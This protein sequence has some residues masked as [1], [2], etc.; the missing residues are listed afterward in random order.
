[1]VLASDLLHIAQTTFTKSFEIIIQLGAICAVVVVYWKKLWNWETIKKLVVAFIPTGVVGLVL[2]KIVKAYL[3]GN[4][5]VVLW[6]LLIGGIVII[7]F[8]RLYKE[9]S[10]AVASISEISYKQAFVIGVFQSVAIVPG[11]SRSLATVIGGLWMGLRRK[12][13]VEFSFLL[14][15]PTMLAA[16]GLD[17]V[18]NHASFSIDQIASLTIGFLVSFVVALFAIRFLL[19]YIQKN[20]FTVFGWYRIAIAILFWLIIVR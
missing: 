8:E 10:G 17:I 3:V 18:K 16:S 1:M 6:A 11:V 5:T 14:A 7:I 4:T 9:Y 19:R 15:V 20:T 2:Y 12:T 13:I